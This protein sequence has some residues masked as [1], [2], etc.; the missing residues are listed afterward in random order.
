[1]KRTKEQEAVMQAHESL[2]YIIKFLEERGLYEPPIFFRVGDLLELINLLEN[3]KELIVKK[4][5]T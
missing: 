4:S 2:D 5:K 1:M 3:K